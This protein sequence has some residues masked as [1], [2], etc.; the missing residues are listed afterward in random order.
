MGTEQLLERM[1]LLNP[2]LEISN[3][4]NERLLKNTQIRMRVFHFK[5]QQKTV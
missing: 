3:K 5:K 4:L 2:Q 1:N